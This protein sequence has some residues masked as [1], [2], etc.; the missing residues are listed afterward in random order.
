LA[1]RVVSIFTYEKYRGILEVLGGAFF[2]LNPFIYERMIEQP[3]IALGSILLGYTFY[4]L[5][6]TERHIVA[7]VF[8]GCA[9]MVMPHASYMILFLF[10]IYTLFFV[11]SWRWLLEMVLAGLCVLVLNLNW[12]TAP[13]LGYQSLSSMISTFSSEN[14]LAF[15]TASIAPL[16]VFSTNILLYGYWG[17]R[18]GTAFMNF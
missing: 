3:M 16:D 1:R 17:E 8:A 10:L 15:Q 7:G 12:I 6:F 2:I 14:L 11:R 18:Y 4:F 13:Y 5:Y 9:F